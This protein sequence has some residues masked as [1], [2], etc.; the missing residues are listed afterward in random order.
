MYR[1]Q[2]TQFHIFVIQSNLKQKTTLHLLTLEIYGFKWGHHSSSSIMI[3]IQTKVKNVA[4]LVDCILKQSQS[5]LGFETLQVNITQ[6]IY[7][8][9]IQSSVLN[10]LNHDLLFS[11][12]KFTLQIFFIALIN[13]TL[14][15][16]T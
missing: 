1:K 12:F 4:Y 11:F 6:K 16:Q 9:S 5:N 15:L 3:G 10:G 8:N 14:H 2:R 7:P 13:W